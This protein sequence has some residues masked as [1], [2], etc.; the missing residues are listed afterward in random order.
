MDATQSSLKHGGVSHGRIS[1]QEA[2][3]LLFALEDFNHAFEYPNLNTGVDGPP[4]KRL[5][6]IHWSPPTDHILIQL[7]LW[8]TGTTK[9]FVSPN[10]Q[11]IV[12]TFNLRTPVR[13][14]KLG[15]SPPRPGD[16]YLDCPQNVPL[17]KFQ[18]RS[19][20]IPELLSIRHKLHFIPHRS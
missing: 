3:T 11:L 15:P 9:M 6:Q 2:N 16:P 1:I 10:A 7:I 12:V 13:Q 17:T 19:F 8:S 14:V 18:V 4:M 20:R 5:V